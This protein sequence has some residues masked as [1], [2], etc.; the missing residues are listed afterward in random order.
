MS[1]IEPRKLRTKSE[2]VRV[3]ANP[4]IEFVGEHDASD[5]VALKRVADELRSLI[6]GKKNIHVVILEKKG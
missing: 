4:A 1:L 2:V 5:L 3:L 6:R